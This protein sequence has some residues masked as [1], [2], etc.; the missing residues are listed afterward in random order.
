MTSVSSTRAPVVNAHSAG[1]GSSEEQL[2]EA[3]ERGDVKAVMSLLSREATPDMNWRG[4]KGR[5]ALLAACRNGHHQLTHM[6][7]CEGATPDLANDA[8]VTPLHLA[9]DRGHVECVAHLLEYRADTTLRDSTDKTA[10][11]Y[12]TSRE[13][14]GIAEVTK[15]L[16][17]QVT[18]ASGTRQCSGEF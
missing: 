1:D 8:G 7:L 6:L 12:A 3:A 13:G 18:D 15:L 9:A 2:F 17:Q 4:V 10:L 14:R 5:T 16:Q 11:D